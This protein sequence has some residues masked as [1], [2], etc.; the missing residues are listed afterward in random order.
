MLED[1]TRPHKRSSVEPILTKRSLADY[2]W[3]HSLGRGSYGEVYYGTHKTTHQEVAIKGIDKEFIKR[4][5][6]CY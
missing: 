4:E 5:K 1:Q 2:D 3:R 6:K